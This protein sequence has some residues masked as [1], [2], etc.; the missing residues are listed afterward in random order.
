M[1]AEPNKLI[2]EAL[3]AEALDGSTRARLDAR[4]A[5][6]VTTNGNSHG[7]S[8]R[9]GRHS[10]HAM[11]IACA[12]V[13][14]VSVGAVAIAATIDAP[15]RK[16]GEPDLQSLNGYSVFDRP[17]KFGGLNRADYAVF[18]QLVGGDPDGPIKIDR[19]I[20]VITRAD[21]PERSA[22]RTLYRNDRGQRI[23]AIQLTSGQVC[24][25]GEVSPGENMSGCAWELEPGG[26]NH[27]G[28]WTEK[29]GEALFGI[30]TDAVNRVQVVTNS[31][32]VEDAHL[33]NNGFWW[34]SDCPARSL[35][36]VG[37]KIT[38]DDKSVTDVALP[39]EGIA[40]NAPPGL[41]TCRGS[42]RLQ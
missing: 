41:D 5:R 33:A 11:L 12:L 42:A 22:G 9:R 39:D 31:G 29:H 14:S 15:P 27:G 19:G 23:S 37:L 38:H 2:H 20:D 17:S 13:A 34:N 25:L 30:S 24:F 21:L 7:V 40:T 6:H 28:V 10:R 32:D 18:T 16:P 35:Y 4:I 8:R 1:L 3:E 26:I 36:A